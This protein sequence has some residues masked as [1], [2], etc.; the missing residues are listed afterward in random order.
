[1]APKLSACWKMG[2]EPCEVRDKGGM[3]PNRLINMPENRRIFQIIILEGIFGKPVLQYRNKL[4][5][6]QRDLKFCEDQNWERIV[7][8]LCRRIES[9]TC[10]MWERSKMK[11][12]FCCP[13]DPNLTGDIGFSW[14]HL[15]NVL[16]KFTNYSVCV[17]GNER[18][19][20]CNSVHTDACHALD[21]HTALLSTYIVGLELWM[22]FNNS[23]KNMEY[24]QST[25]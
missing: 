23:K 5:C 13:S 6:Y 2:W 7:W 21:N 3:L 17:H 4:S 18:V 11:I 9:V 19:I 1:M 16:M 8:A 22:G 15:Q 20:Q 12:L 25:C 14:K 10:V 24:H